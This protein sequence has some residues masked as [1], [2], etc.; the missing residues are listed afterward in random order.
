M[1]LDVVSRLLAVAL[2]I[3]FTQVLTRGKLPSIPEGR[4]TIAALYG[5]GLA[6]CILG[7]F[8][9]GAGTAVILPSWLTTLEAIL[10]L[11][12]TALLLAVLT[13]FNVRLATALLALVTASLWLAT[14]GFSIAVGLPS[15]PLGIATLP[16]IVGA[17]VVVAWPGVAH[18]EHLAHAGR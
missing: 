1:L 17:V 14:L 10:G 18:R 11:V 13:G 4:L 15:A 9:D 7:G 12:A 16:V 8:R 6:L 3:A 2:A 5:A